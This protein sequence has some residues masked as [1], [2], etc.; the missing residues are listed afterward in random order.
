MGVELLWTDKGHTAAV[1]PKA[2]RHLLNWIGG[3]EADVAQVRHEGLAGFQDFV[4]LRAHVHRQAHIPAQLVPKNIKWRFENAR[5]RR[6]HA[7]FG[8][9]AC[10]LRTE[11]DKV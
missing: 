2:D 11:G 10:D 4:W 6:R 3:R 9:Q 7:A 1:Q 8:A 5:N